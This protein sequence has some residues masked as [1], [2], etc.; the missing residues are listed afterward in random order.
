MIRPDLLRRIGMAVYGSAWETRMAN[1]FGIAERRF[2][3]MT[4]G[5][6]PIPATLRDDLLRLM[7]SHAD[8]CRDL[9]TELNGN[10]DD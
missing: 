2:R 4:R 9:I 3:R 7:E 10:G 5:D 8:E 1:E 6:L